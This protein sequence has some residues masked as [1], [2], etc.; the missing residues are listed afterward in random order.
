MGMDPLLADLMDA[1]RERCDYADARVVHSRAESISTRNGRIDELEGHESEGAGIR[2]RR[3]GGW[4]FVATRDL[5]HVGL[6]AALGRALE[7]AEAQP[8]ATAT[9]LTAEP[10]ALGRYESP[11]ERDPFEV[12]T[13]DKLQVLLAADNA[14][15]GDSTIAVTTA[16][17]QAWSEDRIFASTEGALCEQRTVDCG[18]GIAAVAV[19][20]GETQIRS[21]PASFRGDVARAGYEHFAGL[22]LVGHA[23][24]VAEEAVAL[25]TAP[26]CPAEHTTLIL[27]GQQLSLQVHESVGHAIELDRVLGLEASYA[28]TSFLSPDDLGMRRYGSDHMHVSA[29]ATVAG[30]LGT[31]G[32]DDEGV[33]GRR[34]EIVREG[35]LSGF[36]SSRESAAEIGLERSGGC[37]RSSGFDRQPVVRMTNVN[38][39][40][41]EAGSLADLV[42]DT[43]RGILMET[44]RSWSIDS[45]RLNFQFATEIA[46]EVVGGERRRMLRNPS[47]AGVTPEFWAGLDAV[48]SRPEWRLWGVVNCGKGEPGQVDAGL[49]RNCA[50]AVSRRR[51]RRGLS[52]V[53]ETALELAERAL[54]CVRPGDG[55]QVTVTSERSL[56]L[57]FARSRPTQ[58][59]GIDDLTVEITIVRNGHVAG[60]TTNRTSDDG[61]TACAR[62]AERAAEAAA[63]GHETGSH[64]GL[65]GPAPLRAHT[66]HDGETAL[67][68]PTR[69]GAAL[70]AAFAAAAAHGTE[71]HGVWTAA[72]SEVAIAST[73]GVAATDLLT[74]AF[75]KVTAI[76]PGGRSG[77]AAA[78]AVDAKAIDG[79]GLAE[80][81]A[82]KASL[83]G[84]EA[85]PAH[86]PPGEYPVVLE[87]LAVGELLTWLGY[88][89]LNGLAVAE[90]RSALSGH[91]G[92]RVAA[93]RINL[94]DSPRYPG[95]L[96]RAFDFEGVPKAPLPLIQDGVARGIVHDRRSA[97]LAGGAAESTGHALA[98]GG[99]PEGPMPTNLVLVGGGAADVAELCRPIERGVYVTRLWYTNPV[100]PKET[101][102]TGVTRD[103]TFLIEDGEVTR[104]LADMRFSDTVLGLLERTQE[105][106]ARPVLTSEGEFYG[107]R[108]ATGVVCPGLRASAMRFTG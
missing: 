86:L 47:Y 105:L 66:G 99:S 103:G 76:A 67:L 93:P 75:M 85:E 73:S 4:G 18:G 48:C 32:W 59:T 106:S 79:H 33:A 11:C 57:R 8:G 30:G 5:T 102:L 29:D 2:V 88:L 54:A 90:D 51:G 70:D 44:N 10:P 61:L 80:R 6:E 20:D 62:T 89:S 101:L 7:V 71:A 16:N 77:Y 31:F 63:G 108:F 58:A 84:H 87:P 12:S 100:R 69:G 14:M 43:D 95:T 81:A 24:R 9:P 72:E 46:W 52:T 27:D 26:V 17:L 1:A 78:T 53:A 65:A 97:A 21:Y 37:M 45:R 38:L 68:D 25:L 42:A 60:A 19:S 15:R 13:D 74:D 96:P 107:R 82:L 83:G 92:R 64:P 28:G 39:D 55:A 23:P 56:T 3:G 22:D 41:G 34:V 40:P 104:P 49:A 94:S 35:I 50:G 91:L 36:L 98:P